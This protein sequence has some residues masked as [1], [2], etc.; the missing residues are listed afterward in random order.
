MV[1]LCKEMVLK[2]N[3]FDYKKTYVTTLPFGLWKQNNN[4]QTLLDQASKM[5]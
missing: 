4:F 2:G 5:V 1:H 3:G